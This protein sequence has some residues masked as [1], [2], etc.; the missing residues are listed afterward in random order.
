M[1]FNRHKFALA[2]VQAFGGRLL[3]HELH[4]LMFLFRE[5]HPDVTGYDFL[6]GPDG[7]FSLQLAAD[8]KR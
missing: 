1:L 2:F 4:G 3:Q 8:S 6:P 5:D 7:V